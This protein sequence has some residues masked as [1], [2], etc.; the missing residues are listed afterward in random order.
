MDRPQPINSAKE[1][2]A[3]SATLRKPKAAAHWSARRLAKQV[4]L[5][6]AT[7]HRIWQKYGL[8]RKRKNHPSAGPN[9]PIRIK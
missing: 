5:S 9:P 3:I 6:P 4:G 7:V 8:Q 2:A 1:Q